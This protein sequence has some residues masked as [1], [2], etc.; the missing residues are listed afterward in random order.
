MQFKFTSAL[1]LLAA[2]TPAL[3]GL[4]PLQELTEAT[5]NVRDIFDN[6]G[7]T[8]IE[9]DGNVSKYRSQ[10]SV[11]DAKNLQE[12]NHPV[13]RKNSRSK[14]R[15]HQ[16]IPWRIPKASAY[17]LRGLCQRELITESHFEEHRTDNQRFP[18]LLPNLRTS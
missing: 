16:V 6:V 14:A 2:I 18:S 7:P 4:N 12:R 1:S 8:S 15:Y 3:A 10:I 17:N 5:V 13:Q 9:Q 11:Y